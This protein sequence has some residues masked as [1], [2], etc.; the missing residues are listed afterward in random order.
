[1]KKIMSV[2]FALALVLSSVGLTAHAEESNSPN[3]MAPAK[4]TETQKKEL[5]KLQKEILE[6]KQALIKK[7]VEYGLIPKEKGEKILSHL[8]EHAKRMEKEGFK[9]YPH[10]HHHGFK[11]G[12]HEEKQENSQ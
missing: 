12:P 8:E 1:M 2:L 9:F 5:T 10:H 6:K 11:K 4:L 3:K 7:Y